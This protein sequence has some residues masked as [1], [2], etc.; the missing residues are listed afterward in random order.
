MTIGGHSSTGVEG[1]EQRRS[2]FVAIDVTSIASI[3]TGTTTAVTTADADVITAD[4]A[5]TT[6]VS[7]VTIVGKRWSRTQVVR[8][9]RYLI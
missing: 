1:R 8:K 4:A 3:I 2:V 7:V 6:T 5:A 9:V